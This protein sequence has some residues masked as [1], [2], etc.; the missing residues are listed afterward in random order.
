MYNKIPNRR[1]NE[2]IVGIILTIFF[3]S[4]N[5]EPSKSYS[6]VTQDQ[7]NALKSPVTLIGKS[8]SFAGYSVTLKDS[9]GYI[10]FLGDMSSLANDIGSGRA[11]G[12]TIK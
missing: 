11:V 8:K 5:E 12:D 9:T 10:L 7:V 6:E 3:C 2:K 4:C 1:A